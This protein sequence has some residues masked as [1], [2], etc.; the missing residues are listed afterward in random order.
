[1]LEFDYG[2]MEKLLDFT[3]QL[4]TDYSNFPRHTL[5]LISR[6]FNCHR[7][8]FFPYLKEPIYEEEGQN[9]RTA[10]GSFVALNIPHSDMK[11]FND[12]YYK[13]DIFQPKTL[14]VLLRNLKVVT[15]SD[16]MSFEKYEQTEYHDYLESVGLYYQM[17][18]FLKH[19]DRN[20]ASVNLFRSKAE[21]DFTAEEIK[22]FAYLSDFISQQFQIA[23]LRSANL[24]TKNIFNTL[25]EDMK[26]G[27]VM[28][29]S[30]L[31]VLRANSTAREYGKEM[32][33]MV[34]KQNENFQKSL[35]YVAEKDAALQSV[36]SDIGMDLI[37]SN[38]ELS[39]SRLTHEYRFLSTHFTVEN[40]MGNIENRYLV[41]ITRKSVGANLGIE[42]LV[43]ALTTRE[44]EVLDLV[45][46]GQDNETIATQLNVSVYTVRTHISN[47]YKK[48][49]VNSRAALLIKLNK[50]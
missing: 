22:I 47:I 48:F 21:G 10:L 8:L 14:P 7:M 1:M 43:H 37:R 13:T 50:R 4:P 5:K 17:C 23:L 6:Y 35:Y 9:S 3:Y 27:A 33:E 19:N 18:I 28:L 42:D 40:I 38:S 49:N 12:Y 46:N 45:I 44:K 26:I 25:F 24:V 16:V 31:M 29:D 30:H 39:R 32:R 15:V 2:T 11:R 41:I 36:I 34:T 20:V